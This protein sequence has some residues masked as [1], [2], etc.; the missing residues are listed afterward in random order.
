MPLS[1]AASSNQLLRIFADRLRARRGGWRYALAFIYGAFSSLAYSPAD[2]APVLWVSY[3]ALIFLL[4]GCGDMRRAFAVGWLFAFGFFVF[5]L[6]WMAVSMFVDLNHF[7]WAVPLAAFG[8]PAF[9]AFY[10]GIAAAIAQRIG[11]RDVAGALTLAL[12]W[13]LAGYVRGHL[14]TGFPWNMEGYAW[15]DYLPVLQATSLIGIYGLTLLTLTILFLP[16]CLAETAVTKN[17]RWV[18]SGAYI[19]FGVL[20]LWGGWRLVEAPNA[21]VP[22]VRLRL[23]QPDVPQEIKWQP[24]EREK[25]FARLLALTSTSGE[26]PVTAVIWPETASPFYLTSDEEHRSKAAAVV[27]KGGSIIT[28]LLRGEANPSFGIRYYNALA[29]I[30]DHGHIPA[31]YDK[32]HLVPFGEYVPL[33]EWIPVQA[34]AGLGVNFSRGNGPQTLH[35]PGLPL[36]SPLICYEV[37]FPGKVVNRRDPPQWLLNVTNDGWYGNTAGPYQ[38]FAIARVRAVEEGLPLVRVANTGISGIVDPYGR[39]EA[40]LGLGRSGFIDDNLPQPLPA[41]TFF[42]RSGETPLWLIFGLLVLCVIFRRFLNHK[43]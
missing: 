17:H 14:F 1:P 21:T 31:V 30:D 40:R 9:F 12:F 15:A 25:N 3:L 42:A 20:I 37:I 38:H 24:E 41:P 36:F 18:V 34:L 35:A 11:L 22:N 5:D 28:G 29:V 8:V 19:A 7:W 27:P 2:M 4:Q 6:Y 32:F 39:I 26:Q 13:F 23:V 43:T 33:R 16:A 10:Y